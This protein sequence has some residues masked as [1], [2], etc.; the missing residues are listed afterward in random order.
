MN[1][2]WWWWWSQQRVQTS[3]VTIVL[4]HEKLRQVIIKYEFSTIVFH[5]S[6]VSMYLI[7]FLLSSNRIVVPTLH[8]CRRARRDW[9]HVRCVLRF[10]FY[11]GYNNNFYIYARRV[12]F[13][14]TCKSNRVELYHASRDREKVVAKVSKKQKNCNCNRKKEGY[15]PPDIPGRYK[16][17]ETKKKTVKKRKDIKRYT[18]GRKH[19]H[20]SY[21][22]RWPRHNSS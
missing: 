22:D 10:F 19:G 7:A 17:A 5:V 2:D 16:I 9:S 6:G 11:F 20:T 13:G 8:A 14:R 18:A 4:N 3:R 1:R 21:P 12:S 15:L